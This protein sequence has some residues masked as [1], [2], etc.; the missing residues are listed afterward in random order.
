[1]NVAIVWRGIRYSRE[2]ISTG[3]KLPSTMVDGF[4]AAGFSKAQFMELVLGICVKTFS[5]YVCNALNVPLDK[6][7]QACIWQKPAEAA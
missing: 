5:N 1:M 7:F 4:L 3:G 2:L 6:E